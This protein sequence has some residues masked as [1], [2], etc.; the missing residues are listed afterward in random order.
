MK[1]RYITPRVKVIQLL[2]DDNI[3]QFVISS[4]S[5]PENGGLAKPG[6]FEENEED[7]DEQSFAGYSPWE[8]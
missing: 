3:A 4:H 1:Q 5:V 6:L 8:D 2:T 7:A